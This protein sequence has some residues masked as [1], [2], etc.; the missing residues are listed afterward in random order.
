MRPDYDHDTHITTTTARRASFP[1][2]RV[3][4]ALV[5]LG[6]AQ[7]GM[8]PL[9]A[10]VARSALVSER[11][12]IEQLGK[13]RRAGVLERVGPSGASSTVVADG[14]ALSLAATPTGAADIEA[15]LA[16]ESGG[17][18]EA[19][20]PVSLASLGA[21]VEAMLAEVTTLRE[22]VTE[23]V[24]RAGNAEAAVTKLT[25]EVAELRA[26]LDAASIAPLP[27]AEVEPTSEDMGRL[28]RLIIAAGSQSAAA[29]RID[30]T[31]NAVWKA[32]R[33]GSV[34]PRMAAALRALDI[35]R[36]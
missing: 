21:A 18:T 7:G 8:I 3:A 27:P 22:A 12:T 10:D 14:A 24:T 25:S 31:K 9:V 2:L 23:G 19:R 6:C 28:Q 33:R 29:A 32:L 35:E 1:L 5:R 15:Q 26:R 34:S 36:S 20:G 11:S 17:R 13:L 30:S 4:Q 16:G